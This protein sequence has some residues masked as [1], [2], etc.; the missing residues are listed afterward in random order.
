MVIL[1]ISTISGRVKFHKMA[2]DSTY[3]SITV[4]HFSF[5][6]TKFHVSKHFRVD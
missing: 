6:A 4:N 1:L 2:I 3:N 5:T